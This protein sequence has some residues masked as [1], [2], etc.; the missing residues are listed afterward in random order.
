MKIYKRGLLQNFLIVLVITYSIM[1]VVSRLVS[2]YFSTYFYMLVLLLL[3]ALIVFARKKKSLNR[4]VYILFPFIAWKLMEFFVTTD[5]IIMWGYKVLLELIP[6]ILAIYILQ[7]R[8]YNIKFFSGVVIGAFVIT[9]ITTIVGLIS[10]PGAARWMATVSSA[11][12]P[13]FILYGMKNMGGYEFIYSIV[14]LYPLVIFAYKQKKI[15]W[16]V[17]LCVSIGVLTVVVLSE[18]TTAFLLYLITTMLFCVKRDLGKN[19]LILLLIIAVIFG[20]VLSDFL[21]SALETLAD[22]LNSNV[23]SERLRALAGGRSGLEEAEDNRLELY[24][25]SI[26]TFLTHPILGTFLRGGTGIGGHSF[27]LDMLAQYGL[28]GATILYI[29]YKRIYMLFYRQF[30]VKKGYGYVLWLFGQTIFLSCVN[31]GMWLYVLTLYIPIILN[32]IYEAGGKNEN[33]MD[34]KYRSEHIKQTSL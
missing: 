2:T 3:V 23:L 19:H 8:R 9:I 1:P 25:I 34:C 12:D 22:M 17:A 30:S 6:I 5:S 28:G 15:N 14:L 26:N 20:V 10:N 33:I 18:Y 7:Y 32:I 21:S 29:M 27:V 24:M 4:N 13:R 11:N 31:T 16:I